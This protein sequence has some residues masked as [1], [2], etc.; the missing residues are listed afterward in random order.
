MHEMHSL[1]LTDS[2]EGAARR[3]RGFFLE[4]FPGPCCLALRA[5]HVDLTPQTSCSTFLRQADHRVAPRVFSLP[6]GYFL[7][8]LPGRRR[9]ALRVAHVDLTPQR[10]RPT[11]SWEVRKASRGIDR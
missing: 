5:A 9:P 6:R 8:G 11:V 1:G 3:P 7:S 10:L 2:L 4:S